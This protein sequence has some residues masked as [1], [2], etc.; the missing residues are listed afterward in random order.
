M[1]SCFLIILVS[2]QISALAQTDIILYGGKIFTAEKNMLWVEAVAI[3]GDRI[4]AVGK[5]DVI[6]LLKTKQTELIDLKGHVVVPGFNDAHAH[7]GPVYPANRFVLSDDPG[8]STTWEQVR[9]SVQRIA[10]QSDPGTF[11]ISTISPD[12]LEDSRARRINLDSIAPR[13]PVMLTAW[14]GHGKLMNSTALEFFGYTKASSFLGGRLDKDGKGELSGLLEEYA[15]Y[16]ASPQLAARLRPQKIVDDLNA[17]YHGCSALGI[18]SVQNMSTQHDPGQVISVYTDNKFSC[19]VRIM[20]FVLTNSHEILLKEWNGSFRNLNELNDV[21]GV[22]LIMDG[23]PLERLTC[24]RSAYSD[25]PGEFG[26]LNF[27]QAQLR[28]FFQYALDQHQQILLHAGGDSCIRLVIRTMRSMHPDSYWKEK[29]T[30]LE[31]GDFA[32]M[33]QDDIQDLKRLGII[34]VQNPTHLGLPKIMAARGSG[35]HE[36]YSAFANPFG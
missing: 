4:L 10:R 32:I 12:L 14:T 22:K 18:T 8:V 11:I 17:F 15:C 7:V 36:T 19:R 34:I 25:R 24:M 23:T 31:H 6:L 35:T 5:N 30:R 16:Q 20:P 26:R 9:D 28:A 21:S 2:V 3:R 27:N 29:R 13:N 1:R 33:Q